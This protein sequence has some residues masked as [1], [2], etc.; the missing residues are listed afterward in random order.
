MEVTEK[1]KTWKKTYEACM[2]KENS[3]QVEMPDAE[4]RCPPEVVGT[5]F[6]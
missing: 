3:E 5:V 4:E 2:K 6:K 1:G